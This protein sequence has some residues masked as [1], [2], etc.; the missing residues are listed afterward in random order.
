[1]VTVTWQSR[2][3]ESVPAGGPVP[4]SGGLVTPRPARVR[5][6]GSTAESD[7]EHCQAESPGAGGA[8]PA[9][10][11]AARAISVSGIDT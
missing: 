6:I 8:A 7:S 3:G 11:P 2:S 1:M 9:A 5:V 10:R 4:D